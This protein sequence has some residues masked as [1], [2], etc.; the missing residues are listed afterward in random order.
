MDQNEKN[1]CQYVCLDPN[2]AISQNKWEFQIFIL[3]TFVPTV[4]YNLE[5]LDVASHGWCFLLTWLKVLNGRVMTVVE[6]HCGV[7]CKNLLNFIWL[8]MKF[9]NCHHT[10]RIVTYMYKHVEKIEFT[11]F[12]SKIP[13]WIIPKLF[14]KVLKNNSLIW[15]F[16]Y[17]F[18]RFRRNKINK[19]RPH[20][21]IQAFNFVTYKRNYANRSRFDSWTNLLNYWWATA[22][23]FMVQREWSCHLRW[24]N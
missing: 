1:L 19:F 23:S 14:W 20:C 4:S 6:F 24:Q 5:V 9:H 11:N 12:H 21:S 13:I 7:G 15:D 17:F 8:T 22:Q 16:H 2:F 3:I 10:N 18:P